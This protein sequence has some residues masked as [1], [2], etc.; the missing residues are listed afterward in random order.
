[1]FFGMPDGEQ[2]RVLKT[3]AVFNQRPFLF[4]KPIRK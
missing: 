3:H 1:L 2:L 4:E